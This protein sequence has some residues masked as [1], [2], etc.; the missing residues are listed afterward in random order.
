MELQHFYL[1]VL[2]GVYYAMHS[3]LASD[4]LKT[5][6][7]KKKVSLNTWRVIYSFISVIGLILI[8]YRMATVSDWR[9]WPE[10]IPTKLTSMVLTTY[11]LILIRII[12]KGQSIKHFSS[13]DD[14]FN[15]YEKLITTQIYSKVRHPLYSATL[16]IMIGMFL[17]IPKVSTLIALSTT[18]CYLFVG[19]YFEERKLIKKYGETY[20]NYKDKVPAIIP[21]IW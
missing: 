19:I 8:F 9:F 10:N 16:L 1:I 6:L 3:A 18:I 17:F 13:K 11:G 14:R 5:F 15:Q 2:W 4:L 12:F 7:L 21:K 20:L